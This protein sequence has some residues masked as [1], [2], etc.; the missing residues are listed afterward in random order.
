MLLFVVAV[1]IIR[2]RRNVHET[3]DEIRIELNEEAEGM[4]AG[5][6][7]LEAR[8]DLVGHELDFLPG[9]ILAL[10]VLGVA[11]VLR[12]LGSDTTELLLECRLIERRLPVAAPVGPQKTVHDEVRIPANGRREVRV[13]L[14]GEA[15]V[16][17]V[18]GRVCGSLHRAQHQVGDDT[19]AR[20]SL[21]A[22]DEAL[23][24][25]RLRVLAATEVQAEPR[26]EVA[27]LLDPLQ[28]R[29]LMHAEERR[30]GL[31]GQM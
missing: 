9:H 24:I 2:Q 17:A 16:T 25:L 4:N 27:E 28:V 10:G 26:D 7:A 15:E 30:D 5:D 19:L 6:V 18:F 31:P 12:R 1:E 22:A 14:R 21:E 20:L 13:P 11:L 8:P 3:F 29:T 23:E